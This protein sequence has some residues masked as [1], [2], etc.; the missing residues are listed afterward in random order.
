MRKKRELEASF[1]QIKLSKFDHS[2]KM[3]FSWA[4]SILSLRFFGEESKNKTR[5]IQFNK[6][7]DPF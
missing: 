2:E 6:Q 7:F 5:F 4:K 1:P 3:K